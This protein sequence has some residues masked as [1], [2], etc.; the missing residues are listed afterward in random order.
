MRT[1]AASSTLRS[2]I[3][4]LCYLL[5]VVGCF[6]TNIHGIATGGTDTGGGSTGVVATGSAAGSGSATG[7]TSTGSG[8]SGSSGTSSGGTSGTTGTTGTAIVTPPLGLLLDAGTETIFGPVALAVEP[9]GGSQDARLAY[10]E[11][12]GGQYGIMLLTL[13][14]QGRPIGNALQLATTG[15]ILTDYGDG[16]LS[17]TPIAP[18]DVTVADDGTTTTICWADFSVT[19]NPDEPPI[20]AVDTASSVRCAAVP[21]DGEHPDASFANCDAE[22][23][24]VFN[25]SD[26]KTQLF[27]RGILPDS[28]NGL[29]GWGVGQSPDATLLVT[30]AGDTYVATPLPNGRDGV[31][32]SWQL[33]FNVYHQLRPAGLWLASTGFADGGSP[34]TTTVL[35]DP[36]YS[37][38]NTHF[39]ATG[40]PTAGTAAILQYDGLHLRALVWSPD[41]P[42][43]GSWIDLPSSEPPDGAVAV[44]ICPDGYAYLATTIRGHVLMTA[45]AFDGG[46][47]TS[48][49]RYVVLPGFAPTPGLSRQDNEGYEQPATSMATASTRDGKLLLAISNPWQVG[50]YVISCE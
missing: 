30:D 21:D 45:G 24:L 5:G 3:G 15:D 47:D 7:G 28:R 32:F 27:F 41:A 36:T 13:D 50:V 14:S 37:P 25:P 33:D 22:P 38:A 31:V 18:P 35:L 19:P 4:P 49:A 42:D 26:G 40:L 8:G 16:N 23:R 17:L 48:N 44:G 11:V 12:D 34:A 43:A 39:A 46:L 1:L 6:S 20:C 29:L 10:S 2:L 9:N